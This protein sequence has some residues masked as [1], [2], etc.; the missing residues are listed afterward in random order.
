MRE[1]EFWLRRSHRVAV[2]TGDA[3]AQSLSLSSLGMLS[4]TAGNHKKAERRFS[5]ALVVANRHGLRVLEGEI[6]HNFMI[7]EMA[8][9]DYASAEGYVSQVLERYLPDHERL[10]A[11][12]HDIACL[13]MDQ[14]YFDRALELIRAVPSRIDLPAEKFQAFCAAVRAAGGAGDEPAYRWAWS[15]A[16][17]TRMAIGASARAGALFDMGRGAWSLGQ[18]ED[19]ISAFEATISAARAR[20]ESDMLFKA[21]AALEVVRRREGADSR[22][23]PEQPRR[24]APTDAN[25][26]DVIRVLQPALCA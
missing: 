19:A 7:L 10:P 20:G 1:A 6:L 23:I 9:Q 21:E 3:Y 16:V 13:W 18:W 8:R 24:P 14:G 25:A 12:A 15:G 26:R 17:E 4:Y 5:R 11:L 22:H 2:W